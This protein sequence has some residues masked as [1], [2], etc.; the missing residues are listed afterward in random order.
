MKRKIFGRRQKRPETNPYDR[1]FDE[2]TDTDPLGSYTG[3]PED[4]YDMPTQD[5]DDL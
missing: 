4:P 2:F 3:V 5:A 1:P